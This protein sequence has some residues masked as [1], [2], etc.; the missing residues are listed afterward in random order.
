MLT[1]PAAETHFTQLFHNFIQFAGG[2][3]DGTIHLANLVSAWY[4]EAVSADLS[5]HIAG[6]LEQAEN[7]PAFIEIDLKNAFNTHSRQAAF[8]TLAGVAIK[9]YV[10]A[11][12]LYEDDL[13]HLAELQ[14]FFP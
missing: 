6:S 7:R 9:D 1:P 2:T 10:G 4:H 12:V 5:E 11:G 3:K 14:K 8:D 13:P